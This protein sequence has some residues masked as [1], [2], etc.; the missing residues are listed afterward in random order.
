[1]AKRGKMSKDFMLKPKGL[2]NMF[3]LPGEPSQIA[4]RI[5]TVAIVIV[6]VIVVVGL[7]SYFFL[8]AKLVVLEIDKAATDVLEKIERELREP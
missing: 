6:L 5:V 4:C 3:S 1:M 7:V 2:K 8:T